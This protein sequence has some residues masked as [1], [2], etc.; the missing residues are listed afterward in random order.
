MSTHGQNLSLQK[1]GLFAACS[2]SQLQQLGT[3]VRRIEFAD[4]EFVCREGEVAESFH[5]VLEGQAVLTAK[6]KTIQTCSP[7]DYIGELALLARKPRIASVQAIGDS[8]IGVVHAQSFEALL[9]EVPVLA[10]LLLRGLAER[11]WE[12]FDSGNLEVARSD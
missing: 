8:V 5:I 4:S 1:V 10:R 9:V 3:L 7:G 12:G 11:I 6:G 2:D